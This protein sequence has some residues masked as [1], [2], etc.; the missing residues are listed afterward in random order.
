MKNNKT[1]TLRS[2]VIGIIAGTA[3]AVAVFMILINTV[4][5]IEVD[6]DEPAIMRVIECPIYFTD[7]YGYRIDTNANGEW[8]LGAD[9]DVLVWFEIPN[10]ID[11]FNANITSVY[12]Y[13]V[14]AGETGT[15]ELEAYCPRDGIKYVGSLE[16]TAL[17]DLTLGAV[18]NVNHGNACVEVENS[19]DE[20]CIHYPLYTSCA[21]KY[22]VYR[23]HGGFTSVGYDVDFDIN[24]I[25][26]PEMVYAGGPYLDGSIELET[27]A[28]RSEWLRSISEDRELIEWEI[29]RLNEKLRLLDSQAAENAEKVGEAD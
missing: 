9:Q 22:N 18:R 11:Q 17:D 15:I 7:F 23:A 3:T 5:T 21:G 1:R 10:G 12:P 24:P 19:Y 27:E 8:E 25:G 6:F 4:F 16:F 2:I 28:Q 29:Q 14:F 13:E 26:A 20:H